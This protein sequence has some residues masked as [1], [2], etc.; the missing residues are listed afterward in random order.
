MFVNLASQEQ[1]NYGQK[2]IG[3]IHPKQMMHT[4]SFAFWVPI[5][6]KIIARN[7]I[8]RENNNTLIYEET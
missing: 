1:P 4:D 2:L 7:T 3:Y 6:E 5:T 8:E